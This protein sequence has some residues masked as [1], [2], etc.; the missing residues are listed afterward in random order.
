MPG[1]VLG[2]ARLEGDLIVFDKDGVLLDFDFLWTAVTQA[3]ATAIA[4]AAG[5]LD[6]AAPLLDLLGLDAGDHVRPDGLL[7]VGTRDESR[8]AAATLLHQHGLA[9][10]RARQAAGV[11]FETADARIDRT[12]LT[13]PLPGVAAALRAL[14]A[15]G[16][17]LA[18]ATTDQ[19]EG[20]WHFLRVS[21]LDGLFRS[22]VGADR[23]PASKPDPAMFRLACA[24]AGV[25]PARALMVGDVDLDLLMGRA[26]GALATVGVLSG[27]G[28]RALLTPHADH[29]LAGVAD[30]TPIASG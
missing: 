3:R 30:L 14:H 9:W 18:I 1:L 29:L 23:V 22:V 20:A 15:A 10:H 6:L 24:E 17:R 7:A 5:R 25:A 28:D 19:T 8:V 13:R 12:A 27:V 11:G 26:G 16:W 4:T 21:G 2:E